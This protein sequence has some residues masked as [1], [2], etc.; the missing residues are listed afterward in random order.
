MERAQPGS[1]PLE[2]GGSPPFDTREWE[3]SPFQGE[4]N[5]AGERDLG[6]AV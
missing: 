3:R 6:E 1:F 5:E 2:A 4:Q